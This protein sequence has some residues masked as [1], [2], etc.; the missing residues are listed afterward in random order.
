MC[1]LSV[2]CGV[3]AC[4]VCW[5]CVGCGVGTCEVC[6]GCGGVGA[7]DVCWV[8]AGVLGMCGCGGVW[9]GCYVCN[10]WCVWVMTS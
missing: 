6:V 4:D 9:C 7:C 3:G 5:V 1:A 8:C 10:K 2:W